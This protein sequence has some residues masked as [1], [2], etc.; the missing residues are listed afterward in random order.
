MQP[1]K[2]ITPVGTS[3]FE[4]YLNREINKKGF[5]SKAKNAHDRLKEASIRFERYRSELQQWQQKLQASKNGEVSGRDNGDIDNLGYF[6]YKHWAFVELEK[7]S[8]EIAS[9]LAIK[10]KKYPD[11]TIEVYLLATDSV[12]SPLAA[13]LIKQRFQEKPIEGITVHFELGY[14]DGNQR[15]HDV[16]KELQVEHEHQFREIGLKNLLERLYKITQGSFKDVALNMT[17]GYKALVPYLT[18]VGQLEGRP[19][20]YIFET[21][22]KNHASELIE[23][24]RLP[25]Q[26]DWGLAERY[27]PY[28]DD[29]TLPQSDH[30]IKKE[31]EQWQLIGSKTNGICYLTALGKIY[32]AFID[33]H[34]PLG[35]NVFGHFVTYKVFEYYLNYPEPNYPAFKPNV[36]FEGSDL[37]VV[38]GIFKDE[39]SNFI[40]IEVKSYRLVKDAKIK[41]QLQGHIQRF[42]KI[43]KIPKEYRLC[44]YLQKK[45]NMQKQLDQRLYELQSLFNGI[46][47]FKVFFFLIDLTRNSSMEEGEIPEISYQHFISMPASQ[48]A[49]EEYT[50]YK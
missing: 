35:D 34:L 39:P 8:A 19:L 10:R 42:Q 28:L 6:T 20:F 18:L 4:N 16:I 11:K 30:E 5:E 37:D 3:L 29:L 9:I 22:T 36:P 49:I 47:P 32:K 12:L 26:F 17:G 33:N 1:I 46:C 15:E 14:C 7:A 41:K 24:P 23:I 44:I 50:G 48:D 2:L 13:I 40:A 43:G 27:Y 25:V 21:L 31:L 45:G 38:L